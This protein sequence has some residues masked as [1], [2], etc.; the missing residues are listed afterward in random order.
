M[1]SPPEMDDLPENGPA[2]LVR[3]AQRAFA[4]AVERKGISQARFRLGTEI[5]QLRAAGNALFST[6]SAAWSH[7]RVGEEGIPGLTLNVWEYDDN[8]EYQIC[9]SGAFG[10]DQSVALRQR[11]EEGRAFAMARVDDG[12][13]HVADLSLGVAYC[14]IGNLENLPSWE[15]AAPFRPLMNAWLSQKGFVLA[16]A[17]CVGLGNRALLLAGPGGAGKSTTALVCARNGWTHY[18]DDFTL[19]HPGVAP[20]VFPFYNMAKM[21]PDALA[22]FPEWRDRRVPG[23]PTE[24]KTVLPL[25]ELNGASLATDSCALKALVFPTADAAGNPAEPRVRALERREALRLLAPSSVLQLSTG[26]ARAFSRLAGLVRQLP[27][28]QLQ[29]TPDTAKVAGLLRELISSD[30]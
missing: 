7:L 25:A 9:P 18:A 6:V 20:R 16:H 1:I 24:E 3:Q 15:A 10:D 27:C 2:H 8:A 14:S 19:L 12:V 17:S 28:W 11:A 22:F 30:T 13:L 21:R 23:A 4:S 29:L 5:L 26:G